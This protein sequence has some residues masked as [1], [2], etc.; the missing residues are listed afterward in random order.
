MKRRLKAHLQKVKQLIALDDI[1]TVNI[2]LSGGSWIL[3]D[4][5]KKRGHMFFV[6]GNVAAENEENGSNSQE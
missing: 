4:T 3:V 2:F 6:V 1:A 5:Y